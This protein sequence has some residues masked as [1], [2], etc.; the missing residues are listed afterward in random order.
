VGFLPFV[1]DSVTLTFKQGY[2]TTYVFEPLMVLDPHPNFG[3]SVRHNHLAQVSDIILFR[4]TDGRTHRQ[5]YSSWKTSKWYFKQ[6]Q[7]MVYI[8]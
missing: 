5:T 2:R 6:A 1:N 3:Y 8:Y 7:S 4:Q